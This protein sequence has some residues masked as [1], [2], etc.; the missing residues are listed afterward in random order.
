MRTVLLA[1]VS[2]GLLAACSEQPS[3]PATR[4]V[5]PSADVAQGPFIHR[6]SVGGPDDCFD[7][8][9]HPGCDANLSLIALESADGSVSG[10]WEDASPNN[11]NLHAVPDCIEEHRF[12]GPFGPV[13]EAWVG[14]VITGPESGASLVGH[15]VI[16]WVRDRGVSANDPAD[17][18]SYSYPDPQQIGLSSN[19]HDRPLVPGLG[20]V[21]Q[22]QVI[23]E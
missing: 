15:R 12:I 16:I 20:R 6:V 1:F 8:G 23:V 7:F 11:G 10:Q 3:A 14:G 19:C 22:G 17:R 4:A 9:F 21:P 2:L 18:I 5:A 13:A